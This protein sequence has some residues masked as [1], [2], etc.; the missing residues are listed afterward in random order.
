MVTSSR[1]FGPEPIHGEEIPTSTAK[2]LGA[3]AVCALLCVYGVAL[4]GLMINAAF[5]DPEADKQVDKFHV[6]FAI[7]VAVLSLINGKRTFDSWRAGRRVILGADRLQIIEGYGES[8]VV[9]M[10][11]PYW[12]IE[13]IEFQNFAFGL[14][15]IN[16]V[17]SATQD[18]VLYVPGVDIEAEYLKSGRHCRL[19]GMFAVSRPELVKRIQAAI[20][21]MPQE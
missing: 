18:P 20:N 4:L 10:Q 11:L 17:L 2:A 15:H 1:E 6:W 19:L 7:A 21:N 16:V 8:A 12:A 9:K 13:K 14:G 3:V 5:F